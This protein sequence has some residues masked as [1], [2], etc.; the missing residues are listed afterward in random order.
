MLSLS[1]GVPYRVYTLDDPARLV[2]EFREVDWTG[3]DLE[4]FDASNAVSGLRAGTFRPGWSRL[5]ARQRRF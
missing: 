4:A 1:Q 2:L 5:V 3:L